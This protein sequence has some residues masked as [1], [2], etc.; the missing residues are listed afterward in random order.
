MGGD[1]VHR[2]RAH[3]I[4]HKH[5]GRALINFLRRAELLDHALVHDGNF[6]GHGHGFALVV[7][8]IHR[9]CAQAVMQG[10]QFQA[11]QFAE[12]RIE[13]A[14][15]LV[16]HEGQWLA[17]D[18]AP[19]RD[20]LAVT[21]GQTRDRRFKQMRD[22]QRG[23]SLRHPGVDLGAR[24]ALRHQ[25]KGDVLAHRHMRV[26]RKHLEHK[27]NIAGR[28]AFE[29]HVLPAQ[30]NLPFGGQLQAGDHAQGGGFAAARRP[31]QAEKFAIVDHE[32]RVFHRHKVAEG[33]AQLL[34][35]DVG[36]GATRETWK[37]P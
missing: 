5:A 11:H 9:G 28:G 27:G 16:H 12:L 13:C 2:R 26:Q 1:K 23:G 36:H 15:R 14:Q 18:G 24:H 30:K 19:Q 22:L 4:G 7:G 3:E 25:R 33:F 21:A 32:G 35:A 6:V 34:N 31:Q 8:D 17:H 29:C 37:P 10:A 20:P